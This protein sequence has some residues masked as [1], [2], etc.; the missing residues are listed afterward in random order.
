MGRFIAV[1]DHAVEQHLKRFPGEPWDSE[2]RRFQI[3]LTVTD[4]LRDGRYSSREPRWSGDGRRRTGKMNGRERDR[5][6]RW[7]WD[8]N[9]SQLFVVDKQKDRVVV[10]TSIR[11]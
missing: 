10:V 5:T 7:C 8:E 6:I 9:E 2:R 1:S 4:A 11:P 3:A